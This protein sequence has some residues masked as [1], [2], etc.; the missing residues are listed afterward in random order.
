[1]SI[2]LFV[3]DV[4]GT[5]TDGKIYMDSKGEIC[6]VFN[7]KDGYAIHELLR[8]NQV[9]TAIMTGR[10]SKAVEMRAKELE[11]DYCLQGVKNKLEKLQ[12]LAE[13]IGISMESVAFIGDDIPDLECIQACGYSACPSDAALK[14]RNS[15]KYVCRVAGGYGAVRE[16]VEILLNES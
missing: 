5:L 7:V 11:V 12:K 6:K 1:M 8:N 13:E 16:Y 3:M 4:D 15:A 2:K 9:K 14:V 10:E